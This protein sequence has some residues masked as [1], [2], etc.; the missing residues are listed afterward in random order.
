[1]K[2]APFCIGGY[3]TAVIA[4]FATCCWTNTKRQNSYWN[5][6]KYSCAPSW[7]R[8]PASRALERI[9]TQVDQV[10]HVDVGLSPSQPPG[11]SMN[12]YLK[13]SMRTAPRAFTEIEDFVTGP[14][15]LAGDHCP[16]GC[17]PSE[18]VLVGPVADLLFP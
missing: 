9:E 10:G 12:R 2:L 11:W 14:K 1:L 17:S 4:S 7:C 15:A 18:V 13:S 6:L 3:S 8:F 5:Q 16:S